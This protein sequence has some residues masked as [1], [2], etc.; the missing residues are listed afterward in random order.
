MTAHTTESLA[1]AANNRAV[2]GMRPTGALHIGHYFGVLKNWV[3]MQETMQTYFFVADWHA[4]TSEYENPARIKEFIPEMVKDWLV[5][6][7][8]PER[9]VIFRQSDVKEHAELHLLLSMLTPVSWLE[10][11]PTY[12]EMQQQ[13]AEKDLSTYGFLGYPVLMTTDIIMYR[14]RWVPVGQ[15]QVPHVEMT[16]E[17]ARRFNHLYGHFF[18]EPEAHLTP[19]AKCPGLDGRKMSKSYN[20]TI[21]LREGMD[22]L[23]PKIKGMLTDTARVRRAD[24]GEPKNC[25]LYP[26]HEL[27][28][29]KDVC[30]EIQSGCRSAALGCVDCKKILLERLGLFLAPMQERRAHLDEN[31]AY[32]REVLEAGRERAQAEAQKTLHHAREMM[33]L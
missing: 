23:A 13:L 1:H 10:R 16:R 11:C 5:A 22:T 26:Y 14:P 28:T 24:P 27:L 19:S 32:V 31:P 4:L 12:K 15:D 3:A 21:Q 18:P 2:S 7:L 6:G 25:N 9:S 33:G 8:D 29:E 17:I 20:N 30:A